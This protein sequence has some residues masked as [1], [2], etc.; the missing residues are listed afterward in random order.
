MP[1]FIN[2]SICICIYVHN[3]FYYSAYSVGVEQHWSFLTSMSGQLLMVILDVCSITLHIYMYICGCVKLFLNSSCIFIKFCSFPGK[4]FHWIYYSCQLWQNFKMSWW[5]CQENSSFCI[6]W[7]LQMER[8][9]TGNIWYSNWSFQNSSMLLVRVL[10]T[11]LI[12]SASISQHMYICS[13][14]L[15]CSIVPSSLTCICL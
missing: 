13:K 10:T 11:S 2:K 3:F 6:V 4:H 14:N 8:K 9:V 5:N 7:G 12:S 1:A 15:V